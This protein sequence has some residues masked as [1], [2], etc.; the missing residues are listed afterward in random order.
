[1]I[2]FHPKDNTFSPGIYCDSCRRP[3][4]DAHMALALIPPATFPISD[5]PEPILHAH[6]G[7]CTET[8]E[9]DHDFSLMSEELFTP[10]EDI[11]KSDHPLV[12]HVEV[13]SID[14]SIVRSAHLD[15]SSEA[16]LWMLRESG[17]HTDPALHPDIHIPTSADSAKDHA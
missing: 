17:G 8:L 7:S 14:Q 1:M 3:I 4:T 2:A 11:Q 16:F 6:K 10:G 12:N 9:V 5:I 15:D 13:P